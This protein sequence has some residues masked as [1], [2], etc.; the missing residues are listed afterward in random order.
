[1]RVSKILSGIAVSAALA[2]TAAWSQTQDSSGQTQQPAPAGQPAAK[3]PQW[4]DTAEYDLYSSILKETDPNKRLALIKSWEEK[5]PNTEFKDNRNQLYIDT[6][7]KLNNAPMIIST[8]KQMLA[9]NPN[10]F[11]ALY[12]ITFLTPS[13]NKNDADTLDTAEKAANG[14]VNNLDTKFGADKKPAQMSD[15]DWKKARTD[16]EALSHKTLGWVAM[17]RKNAETAESEFRKSLELNPNAGEVSYW[18]GTVILAEKKP[19][20]QAEALYHFARAAS[21]EEA[22]GGL[23]ATARGQVDAYFV[24][25]YNTY[26]GADPAGMQQLR[27]AALAQPVPPADFKIKTQ[28][29]LTVE[30]QNEL[31]KNDP[32]LAI[33]LNL[34]TELTG[35]NGEQ[36][37]STMKGAALPK[38]KGALVSAEPTTRPRE[39]RLSMERNGTADVVLKLSA[40]L[41]GKADPGTPIEFDKAVPTSFTA[42]PL[43]V[44][45]DVEKANI[46]GWPGREA[47]PARRPVRRR[48]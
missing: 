26:H 48:R 7:Q 10:D 24:K 42:N 32:Q 28:E 40:P 22:R 15:A 38:L 20:R 25:A 5:Y 23:N 29:E 3:G 2:M 9:A 47:A 37:F 33:W 19:E 8:A 41:P 6:Y 21:L 46:S 11:T 13:L 43:M 17:Q 4:K 45:M 35:A 36:F 44:T 18:M 30:R 31:Q 16:M 1:M 12:W 39:L 14:L 34:K 27:A